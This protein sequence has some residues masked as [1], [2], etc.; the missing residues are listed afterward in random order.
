[1]RL[2]NRFA[3]RVAIATIC[4][5]SIFS[6]FGGGFVSAEDVDGNVVSIDDETS[7][8]SGYVYGG[9]TDSGTASNNTINIYSG[10]FSNVFHAG[11]ATYGGVS[12]NVINVYG[13]TFSG[14]WLSGGYLGDSSGTAT[15]NV[16]NIY[17]GNFYNVLYIEGSWGYGTHNNNIVNIEGGT[18]TGSTIISGTWLSGDS[19]VSGNRVDISGGEIDGAVITGA[20][21]TAGSGTASENVVNISGDAV[22]TNSSIYGGWSPNGAATNNII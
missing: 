15:G 10:T 9:H 12:G 21:F 18:I 16:V 8:D 7:L 20:Y 14:G 2:R 6:F 4:A 11:D 13:G 5:H 3:L 1:M 19:T 22:I 17:G